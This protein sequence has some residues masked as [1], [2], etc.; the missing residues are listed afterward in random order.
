MHS[1]IILNSKTI[2]GYVV[3]QEGIELVGQVKS[4]ISYI[5]KKKRKEK[6][7]S[8][9]SYISILIFLS[10]GVVAIGGHRFSRPDAMKTN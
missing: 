5:S 9:I 3:T 10:C 1:T 6:R 2:R 8:E 4:E 7:K